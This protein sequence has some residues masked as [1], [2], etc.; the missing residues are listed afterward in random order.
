MIL[1]KKNYL[2][3][4]IALIMLVTVPIA[5]AQSISDAKAKVDEMPDDPPRHYNLGIAYYKDG[6]YSDAIAA[7]KKAVELRG[8]YKE[9]YYMMG[10]SQQKTGQSS[11]A[12]KSLKKLN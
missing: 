9:A 4:F 5:H 8:D 7:L 6:Q 10:L 1:R 2:T 11:N 3:F 12:I